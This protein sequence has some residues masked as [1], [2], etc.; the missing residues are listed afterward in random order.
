MVK[1]KIFTKF[2]HG[3]IVELQRQSLLQCTI[4]NE[5]GYSRTVIVTFIKNL[6]ANVSKRSSGHPPKISPSQD[7]RIDKRDSSQ[8]SSQIE[9]NTAREQF[10][11]I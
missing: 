8:T 4:A 6:D 11:G 1:G 7:R 3:K 2:E 5:I 9:A 10:D